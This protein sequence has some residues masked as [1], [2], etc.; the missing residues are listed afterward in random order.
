MK[1]DKEDYFSDDCIVKDNFFISI[2]DLLKCPLCN[3]I[4]KEPYMCK[5]C[6][7][8]Y[9]KKCLE[10]GEYIIPLYD[11]NELTKEIEYKCP[12]K[13]ENIKNDIIYMKI[14]ENLKLKLK[15]CKNHKKNS[16]TRTCESIL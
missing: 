10:N 14:D 5:D 7:S 9:C 12:S 4:L 13:H 1:L 8:V 6:Q 15:H 16:E 3:K 2:E 11:K